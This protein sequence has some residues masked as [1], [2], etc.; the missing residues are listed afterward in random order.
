M[1]HT[2]ITESRRTTT[3][4]II[5]ETPT[6]RKSSSSRRKDRSVPQAVQLGARPTRH[7]KFNPRSFTEME[8]ELEKPLDK[9]PTQSSHGLSLQDPHSVEVPLE[10]R[11]CF[12]GVESSS[13]GTRKEPGKISSTASAKVLL[14]EIIM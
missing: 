14:Y 9:T 13:G 4:G 11:A 1:T 2:V 7:Q 3:N 10:T 6:N 12:T 5:V 8:V